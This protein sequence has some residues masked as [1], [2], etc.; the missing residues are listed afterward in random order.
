MHQKTSIERVVEVI[1]ISQI[2]NIS[3]LNRCENSSQ[4][5]GWLKTCTTMITLTDGIVNESKNND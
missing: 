3:Q 4:N 1:R 5:L 2:L